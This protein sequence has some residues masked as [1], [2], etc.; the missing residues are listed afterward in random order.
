MTPLQHML[1]VI[2]IHFINYTHCCN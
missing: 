1:D 2:Q